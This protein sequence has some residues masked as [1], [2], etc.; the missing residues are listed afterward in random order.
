MSA[1]VNAPLDR[2][3]RLSA[4]R[5]GRRRENLMPPPGRATIGNLPAE[6]TSFVGRRREPDEV[7]GLLTESRLVTL[8]GVGG[9]GKTRLALRVAADVRRA[10]A[11]GA[12]FVDLTQLHEPGQL[13]HNTQD[14]NVLAY[15]VADV[16]RLR[17][18]GG[19]PALRMLVERLADRRLL[20]VL[21]NCEHLLPASAILAEALSRGCPRLRVL[22]TSREPLAIAGETTFLVPPLPGPGPGHL[23][24]LAELGRCESVALFLTRAEEVVAEF[25]LTKVN[26]VAVAE[27]CHRLDGLPLAIEL[28]APWVRVLT[29][30]QILDRLTDR[31]TLLSRGSRAAP[32]RQQTLR[33]CVDWSFDLCAEPE[34]RLWARLSV[35]AG[36]FEV[37][38]VEGICAD[39]HLPEADLVD[40]VTGLV[41]KSILVRAGRAGHTRYLM[42]ETIRDYGQDKLH[43]AGESLAL[44]RR[45][46]DW[47]YRLLASAR[48]E[49]VSD[50]QPYWMARLTRE[51]PNLRTAV[52]FCL[53]EP[54][55]AENALR[56]SVSLPGFYWP[57]RGVFGEG[58]RWLDRALAQVRT[59]SALR[60]QALLV[61]SF[62]AATQGDATA[63]ARLLD[64]GQDLAR[65]LDASTELAHAAYLRGLG[66]LFANDLPVA[67]ETLNRARTTLSEDPDP[68]LYLTVL[69]TLGVAAGLNGDYERAIACQREVLGIVEPR[70]ERLHQSY[71]LFLGGLIAW[72]RGDLHQGTAQ[73]LQSLRLKRAWGS[74]D[75]YGTALCLEVLAWIAADE[76]QHRRAATL[77]GAA[78]ALLAEGGTPITTFGHLIGHHTTC[79]RQIRGALGDVALAEAFHDGQV[80]TYE[81]AIAYAIEEPR[82]PA[83][84]PHADTTARLTR[85]EQQVADLIARGLSNKDIAAALA[86]SQR[87]AETHV[88]HILT[89]LGFTNRAQV[90]ALA[91]ERSTEQDS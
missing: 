22:A 82:Q 57:A 8:T 41:D 32:R 33:A 23:P 84:A 12:W 21:D 14:P 56:L 75:R 45:H 88:E 5:A 58:R 51:H 73:E 39:Q 70:G 65:R 63:A 9:T 85:R 86:I 42:L 37:D 66:P 79:E 81:E 13:P 80:L 89:K 67:V 77:L 4:A 19:G 50:R 34:R 49:W 20:L 71:A 7:K 78:D 91:S 26:H 18:Q 11:D 31:F 25:S 62:L 35:F 40:L 83:P 24:G 15:L 6:L 30:Q 59:A 47:Y 16:L 44:R 76:Q 38:A 61:S 72:L 2:S 46:R 60:A 90:A 36:G 27:L 28:A 17:E 54:G 74:E 53:T 10:F 55:E 68:D 52:D 48:A 29:P 3:D 69:I 64:E 43:E 1:D 87:T